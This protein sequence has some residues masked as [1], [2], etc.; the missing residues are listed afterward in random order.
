MRCVKRWLGAVLLSALNVTP[1]LAQMDEAPPSVAPMQSTESA[2]SEQAPAQQVTREPAQVLDTALA[3]CLPS[4]RSGFVCI[5]G[6]CQSACNPACGPGELCTESGE[7]SSREEQRYAQTIQRH[8]GF[9]VRLALG[10]GALIG[11][12]T[13]VYSPFDEE[14]EMQGDLSGVAQVGALMIGGTVASGL[15]LGGGVWGVN[16]PSATYEGDISSVGFNANDVAAGQQADVGLASVSLIGPFLAWY[17]D[18]TRGLYGEL[19]AGLALATIGGVYEQTATGELDI[20]EYEGA[21]WGAVLGIG[22]DFW[23]GEQWSLG[24]LGRVSYTSVSVSTETNTFDAF[25]PAI[26]GT[27]TY[28]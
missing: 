12:R 9:Y 1:A 3:Q 20:D 11:S 25:A 14:Y 2:S 4:C 21:G 10:L 17:P 24:V 6:T 23:I 18:P 27:A 19:G 15:V 13:E 5:S 7:C 8:D 28:H 26:A 22:Y 16:A